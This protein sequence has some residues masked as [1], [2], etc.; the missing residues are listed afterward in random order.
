MGSMNLKEHFWLLAAVIYVGG[1]FPL[2]V[3]YEMFPADRFGALISNMTYI[4]IVGVTGLLFL[5]MMV[6]AFGSNTV[7]KPK[8]N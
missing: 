7:S 1:M 3:L 2:F 5:F 4:S 8:E 6:A